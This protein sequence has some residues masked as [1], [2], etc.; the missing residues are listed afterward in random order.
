ME[1]FENETN[2]YKEKNNKT[3]NYNMFLINLIHY[4]NNIFFIFLYKYI[5]K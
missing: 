3:N 1:P 4:F 5:I 2:K